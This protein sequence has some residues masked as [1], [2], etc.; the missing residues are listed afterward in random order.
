ML[1]YLRNKLAA[2]V[3]TKIR[4][5]VP[6]E[7]VEGAKEEHSPAELKCAQNLIDAVHAKDPKAVL[8]AIDELM[9]YEENEEPLEPKE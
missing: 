1:P 4:Q 7:H 8:K 6:S 9:D 3:A 5:S 2:G